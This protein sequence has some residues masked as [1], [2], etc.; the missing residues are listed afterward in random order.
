MLEK[1]ETTPSTKSVVIVTVISLFSFLL[2]FVIF[3][4]LSSMASSPYDIISFEFAMTVERASEILNDWKQ[5]DRLQLE[6]FSALLDYAY[7]IAYSFLLAGLVL[8]LAR[9]V[10]GRLHK[11]GLWFVPLPFIAAIFDAVEN[12]NLLMMMFSPTDFLAL[13][14]LIASICATVKFT[15]I[16]ISIIW[17]VITAVV[18]GYQKYLKK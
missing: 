1:L 14:P 8:L 11:T 16:I 9:G 18:A 17:V 2:I 7:M 10:E 4:V 6:I 15:L 3:R 13:N 5:S 12:I